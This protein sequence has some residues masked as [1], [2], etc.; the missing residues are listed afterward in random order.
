VGA[1]ALQDFIFSG[2]HQL[3]SI[4]FPVENLR[5]DL[6]WLYVKMSLLNALF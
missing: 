2:A 1:A 4:D 5:T 3:T 6:Y